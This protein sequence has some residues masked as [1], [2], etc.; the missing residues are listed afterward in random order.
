MRHQK[1][2]FKLNRFTSLRASTLKSITRALLIYQS[3]KTTKTR[4]KAAQRLIENLITLGKANTLSARR[5]AFRELQDHHLVKRLF[6]EI[7]PL[8]YNR[9]GGY[10]RIINL[11]HR[12]GDNAQMVILELT[13]KSP[14]LT[15]KERLKKKPEEKEKTIE[16]KEIPKEERPKVLKERLPKRFLGGLRSFFKKERD[17]L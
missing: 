10:T 15:R 14:T 2:R 8:F 13:E 5:Q 12:R 4:A 3:I 17:S 7:S 11:G 9:K 16:R 6:D 1:H